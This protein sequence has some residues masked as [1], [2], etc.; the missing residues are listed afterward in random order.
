MTS[1]RQLG[2]IFLDLETSNNKFDGDILQI[3][4][5][6]TTETLAPAE[7][8]NYLVKLEHP[9]R[10]D[11]KILKLIGYT[12]ERWQSA[13]PLKTVLTKLYPLGKNRVLVGWNSHFDWARLEKAFFE[14]GFD[15][16]F[17]YQKLD[18]LSMA[19]LTF[20]DLDTQHS[21]AKTAKRFQLEHRQR[22]NALDDA[23]TAYRLFLA[24]FQQSSSQKP[25]IEQPD[26][27][28]FTDGGVLNNPGPAAIGVSIKIQNAKNK[29][30][31]GA[32]KFKIKE[33]SES[34]GER[35]NNQA[36]YEAVLFA[37]RKVKTL[38]GKAQ[39]K[40]AKIEINSDSELIVN[41]LSNKYKIE[42]PELQKLFVEFWNLHFDFDNLEFKQIPREHNIAHRLVEQALKKKKELF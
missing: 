38:L 14:N 23:Y 8:F 25:K 19:Y 31:N 29:S 17:H 12:D 7:E 26:V 3:A 36:E 39:A 41:Q 34:I 9:N 21:L 5:L 20:Q 4:G 37:L 33:Y 15:D 16:P 24:L 42:E 27:V 22:H 40:Q 6:T 32:T 30:Q 13:E 10:A 11:P 28:I 2:F 1:L 35:T 18:V